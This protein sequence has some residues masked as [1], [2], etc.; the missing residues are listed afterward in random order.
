MKS[1]A[2]C[3]VG[4]AR[5]PHVFCD[6]SSES[7]IWICEVSISKSKCLPEDNVDIHEV[8]LVDDASVVS[9]LL[10]VDHNE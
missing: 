3:S 9:H 7:R 6:D 2:L 5:R 10:T 8:E 4:S 1:I